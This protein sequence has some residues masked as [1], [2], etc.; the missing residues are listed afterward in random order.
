MTRELAT[1]EE[2]HHPPQI[3]AT[4][5][6]VDLLKRTLGV[7]LTD[8]ELSLFGEVA[9]RRGLDPFTGQIH[10]V[11]RGGRMTIQTSIDGY[12]LI[13]DRTGKYTGQIGPQW[14]GPDGAWR[15]VWLDDEPPAAARV[16]V[17][18]SDFTKPLYGVAV[19]REYVQ[20]NKDGRPNAMW[21]RMSALM[22]SKTAEALALRKAFPAELSGIYTTEEMAQADNPP[23]TVVTAAPAEPQTPNPLI[24][25]LTQ[26][27]TDADNAE[28]G[29]GKRIAAELRNTFLTGPRQGQPLG[30]LDDS[31][32]QTAIAVAQERLAEITEAELPFD[33]A[34]GGRRD[35]ATEKNG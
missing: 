30:A 2:Q 24:E 25:Q 16:G 21:A 15:D 29:A 19:W 13:A 23:T 1:V 22:L 8:D 34:D 26:I 18:R 4:A 5:E 12:R 9:T 10:A 32:L 11:K 35:D 6:H 33:G 14:C 7:D 3:L 31:T 20:R 27:L 17:L 28:D